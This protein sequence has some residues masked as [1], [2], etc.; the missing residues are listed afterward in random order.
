[1]IMPDFAGF[2][3]IEV[4]KCLEAKEKPRASSLV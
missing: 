2:L 4:S 1:M 3:G